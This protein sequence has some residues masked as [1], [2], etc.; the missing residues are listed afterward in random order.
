METIK[1][2]HLSGLSMTRK[3][4][5]TFNGQTTEHCSTLGI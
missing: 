4:E 2:F 3:L 1:D 5:L